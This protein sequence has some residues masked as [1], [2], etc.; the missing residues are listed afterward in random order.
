[1]DVYDFHVQ[2][3]PF[4]YVR[5]YLPGTVLQMNER[6]AHGLT[7]VLSGELCI[8]FADGE[9]YCAHE[10]DIIL[11]RYRDAYRL[12]AVG[13]TPTEYIVISYLTREEDFSSTILPPCRLFSTEHRRRY[14]DA[15]SRAAET[16]GAPGVCGN[17]LLR[18]LVQQILCHIIQ[19]YH[20]RTISKDG[21]LACAKHFIESSFERDIGISDIAAA[22]C[23]SPSHLRTLF[24]NSCGESPIHYL[25]RM[26][27][28]HAKEMLTS[29]LFRLEEIASAC[30]FRNVYYFSRVFKEYTGISPGKY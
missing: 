1:M 4:A 27:I 14:R 23:C 18:A 28:E 19:E 8:S 15:F 21:P 13:E 5:K 2:S 17:A 16:H 25:N 6:K 7:L 3:V 22:A 26:R 12:E 29:N 9:S 20:T 11:Q 10:G 30:G 24:R